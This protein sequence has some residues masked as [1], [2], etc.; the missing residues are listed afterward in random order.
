[1]KLMANEADLRPVFSLCFSLHRVRLS[2]QMA[3]CN[4]GAGWL[5]EVEVVG[6]EEDANFNLQSARQLC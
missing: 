6:F 4:R 5:K 3:C 1:M 2:P